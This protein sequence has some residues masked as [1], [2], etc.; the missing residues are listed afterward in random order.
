[1]APSVAFMRSLSRIPIEVAGIIALPLAKS[2]VRQR[3]SHPVATLSIPVV[4]SSWHQSRAYVSSDNGTEISKS[5]KKQPSEDLVRIL[6]RS[7]VSSPEDINAR[8]P[9]EVYQ[10]LRR[11]PSLLQRLERADFRD[12]LCRARRNAEWAHTV[13]S[14]MTRLPH[15][16]PLT[17]PDF[18]LYLHAQSATW[19]AGPGGLSYPF[20]RHFLTH[21][22]TCRVVPNDSTYGILVPLLA[23]R[24]KDPD[25]AR[26]VIE[27]QME[28]DGLVD[29]DSKLVVDVLKGYLSEGSIDRADA[30]LKWIRG[31]WG[32]EFEEWVRT[33]VKDELISVGIDTERPLVARKRKGTELNAH[34]L[35]KNRMRDVEKFHRATHDMDPMEQ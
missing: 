14:D 16:H 17:Q 29:M 28:Q 33:F 18:H 11:N 10:L 5:D 12:L 31:R 24:L 20:A 27:N 30:G 4:S 9:M 25:A 22:R 13:F 3:Y 7:L 1:M 26:W 2:G 35:F 15:L 32:P 21:M 8:D 6:R 19:V 23:D 34:E